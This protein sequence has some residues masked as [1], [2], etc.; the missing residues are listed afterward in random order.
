MA[1]AHVPEKKREKLD[2]TS[3][4]CVLVGFVKDNENYVTTT[5]L[6]DWHHQLG[7][8]APPAWSTDADWAG[9]RSDRK[10]TSG[11]CFA[12]S[13]SV[14]TWQSVK[15]Y[16]VTLPTAEAEYVALACAA[17]EAASLKQLLDDL[18]FKTGGPM[19]VNED[20][21]SDNCLAQ[22][23]NIMVEDDLKASGIEASKHTISSALRREGLRSHNCRRTLLLQKRQV[24]ARPKYVNH[25][26]Q[27]A[28]FWNS[29][30]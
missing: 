28:A 21:Q 20:N 8:L 17:Q 29:V 6:V 23:L 9:D 4:I 10:S 16:C 22:N 27:P 13:N 24:K 1:Y 26:N 19:V 25:L 3:K 30:L 15:Q 11:C 14:I 2:S 5:S 18:E 12:L 7:R